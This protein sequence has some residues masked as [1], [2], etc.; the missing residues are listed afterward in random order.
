METKDGDDDDDGEN[1][2]SLDDDGCQPRDEV[3]SGGGRRAAAAATVRRRRTDDDDVPA[4]H[5]TRRRLRS[6][7]W[8]DI[9]NPE[10]CCVVV[11]FGG[12]LLLFAFR[13]PLGC[14]CFCFEGLLGLFFD[15]L[16]F[17]TYKDGDQTLTDCRLIG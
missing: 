14:V 4:K 7:E 2:P 15:F 3:S 10:V 6:A 9:I 5:A 17:E 11:M 16:T 1:D 13:T 8:R 12:S